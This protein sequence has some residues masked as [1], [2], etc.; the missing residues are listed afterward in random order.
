MTPS[1]YRARLRGLIEEYARCKVSHSWID[2]TSKDAHEEIIDELTTSQ[3]TLNAELR[4]LENL[5]NEIYLAGFQVSDKH[6]TMFA[7]NGS[8]EGNAEWCKRR[9]ITISALLKVKKS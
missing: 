9:D 8:P 5:I 1:K 2:N 7:P 6:Q 3:A 4:R